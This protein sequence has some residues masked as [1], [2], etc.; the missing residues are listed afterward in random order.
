MEHCCHRGLPEEGGVIL[1]GAEASGA[2]RPWAPDQTLFQLLPFGASRRVESPP[3]PWKCAAAAKSQSKD[4]APTWA[5]FRSCWRFMDVSTRTA[6]LVDKLSFSEA[7]DELLGKSCHCARRY[8]N[9][10]GVAFVVPRSAAGRPKARMHN[11]CCMGVPFAATRQAQAQAL[12]HPK[13]ASRFCATSSLV[14]AGTR[15]AGCPAFTTINNAACSGTAKAHA[16][17]VD[18]CRLCYEDRCFITEAHERSAWMC[19]TVGVLGQQASCFTMFSQKASGQ[20]VCASS[21]AVPSRQTYPCYPL[22][23]RWSTRTVKFFLACKEDFG[24]VQEVQ[25]D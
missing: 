20:S 7:M 4:S 8:P 5:S 22:S 1:R 10:A 16:P 18:S 12:R 24:R 11:G 21:R 23:L 13:A 3:W 14:L 15:L 17:L 6:L 19:C 2:T 25:G 9:L